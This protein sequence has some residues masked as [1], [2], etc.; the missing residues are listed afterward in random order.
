MEQD[1]T[2]NFLHENFV[3]DWIAD[4]DRGMI[5]VELHSPKGKMNSRDCVRDTSCA[6]DSHRL[7]MMTLSN[8]C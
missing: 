6:G 8:Q 3:D 5:E 7:G 1:H 2:D 4:C